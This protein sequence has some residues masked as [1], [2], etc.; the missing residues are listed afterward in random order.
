MIRAHE[1]LL[2]DQME[3][4]PSSFSDDVMQVMVTKV[5]FIEEQVAQIT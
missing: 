4:I 5:T 3:K 2:D 1:L